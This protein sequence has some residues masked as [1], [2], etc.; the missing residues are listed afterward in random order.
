MVKSNMASW[1]KMLQESPSPKMAMPRNRPDPWLY[2]LTTWTHHVPYNSSSRSLPTRVI[3]YMRHLHSSPSPFVDNHLIQVAH[4]LVT[5][6]FLGTMP[7]ALLG[8]TKG[9]TPTQTHMHS[10]KQTQSMRCA[11]HVLVP[12]QAFGHIIS[13][14]D[15]IEVIFFRMQPWNMNTA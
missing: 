15:H 5:P 12:Y 14:V 10:H 8:N 2:C 1:L 11:H 6:E 7:M 4:S 3:P 13:V 9:R